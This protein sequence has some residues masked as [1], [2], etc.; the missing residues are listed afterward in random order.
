MRARLVGPD[1]AAWGAAL[2]A[3][4][5]DVHHLPGWATASAVIDGGAPRAVLVEEDGA[6]RCVAPLLARDLDGPGGRWDAVSPYGYAGPAFPAGLDD[7]ARRAALDAAADALADAGCVAWFLRLHPLLDAGWSEGAPGVRDHG[8]TVSIDL[9]L[10]DA[11]FGRGLRA[12]HRGDVD[13]AVRDGVEVE[14][15]AGPSDADP[16]LAAFRALYAA[17]M[18]RVGADPYY[19]F[20]DAYYATLA[21]A[22][23]D[24][25]LVLV[26]RAPDGTPLAAALFT[27]CASARVGQ[28]HL[29]GP[30]GGSGLQATKLVIVAARAALRERGLGVL[31]LGGG[32]GAEE[33]SLFRFKAGFSPRRHTYRSLRR[34]L[35]ADEYA[36]R[37]AAVGA[38]P[39]AGDTGHFPAYRAGVRAAPP[40]GETAR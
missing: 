12:G 28:Y 25:L 32:R 19:A 23:S 13:R 9:G 1:D 29:S 34:V 6:V 37:C 39:A 33:D 17:T 38:D 2:A 10:D 14:V 15:V 26:A 24:D 7:A 3:C 27:A 31:H 36:R 8:R 20:P 5:H 30:A 4:V 22:L 11:A 35:D 16:A 21:A 40:G 18:D